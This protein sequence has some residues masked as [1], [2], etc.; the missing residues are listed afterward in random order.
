[1]QKLTSKIRRAIETDIRYNNLITVW[2]LNQRRIGQTPVAGAGNEL[3]L[4]RR[5]TSHTHIFFCTQNWDKR[6]EETSSTSS[7]CI[8]TRIH[9]YGYFWLQKKACEM[10]RSKEQKVE[11]SCRVK[12]VHVW[13]KQQVM[14]EKKVVLCQKPEDGSLRNLKNHEDFYV[15]NKLLLK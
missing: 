2:I 13:V 12:V 6:K 8:S 10:K 1:M 15:Q 7:T 3:R 5:W 9:V 11:V 4:P 14:T